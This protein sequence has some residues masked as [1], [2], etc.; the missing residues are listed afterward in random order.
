LRTLENIWESFVPVVKKCPQQELAPI[1]HDKSLSVQL[2]I[3]MHGRTMPAVLLMDT[4]IIEFFMVQMNSSDGS[5]ILKGSNLF[6]LLQ[7]GGLPNLMRL[8]SALG[9]I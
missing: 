2:F 7:K 1:I 3:P 5:R 8:K 4:P 9:F 6:G